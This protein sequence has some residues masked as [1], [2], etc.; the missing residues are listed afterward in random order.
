M[1]TGREIAQRVCEI[2]EYPHVDDVMSLHRGRPLVARLRW[3]TMALYKRQFKPEL[4]FTAVGR[5]FNRD[6]TTVRHGL[7]KMQEM[8]DYPVDANTL[9]AALYRIISKELNAQ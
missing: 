6:R 7:K 2:A 5:E 1:K 8:V 3:V 4:S 9:P